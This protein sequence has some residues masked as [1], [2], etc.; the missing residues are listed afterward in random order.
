M[1][2]NSEIIFDFDIVYGRYTFL[3]AVIDVAQA[4]LSKEY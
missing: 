2:M 3:I 4:F 1:Q